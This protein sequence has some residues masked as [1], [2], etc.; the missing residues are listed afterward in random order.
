M[1]VAIFSVSDWERERFE[2]LKGKGW[3]IHLFEEKLSQD[4][5]PSPEVAD[6]AAIAVFADCK[7]GE[8][9]LSKFNRLG[10]VL[11]R[12]T[13]YDHIDLE[14]CRSRGIRVYFVPDYGSITVAEYTIGLMLAL[15][16][17]FRPMMEQSWHGSFRRANLRGLDLASKTV[18]LVGTGRIGREVAKRLA[19]FSTQILAFDKYPSGELQSSL[20]NLRYTQLEDLYRQSQIISFHVPLTEETKHIF[21]RDSLKL[22]KPSTFL[23]NTSRGPVVETEAIIEGLRNG[24]L[25][26][27]AL[28][29]FE[30][31]Q[32]LIEQEPFLSEDISQAELR[33]ALSTYH[34]LHS[35]RVILSP[36]NAYNTEEALQRIVEA[37]IAN[38]E[39]FESNRETPTR[40][41]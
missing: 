7:V 16:R 12:S 35:D 11:T 37:T 29:T 9:V 25:A 21:N 31:E 17:R 23:V 36:H 14:A 20:P 19:A 18:G 41:L 4:F 10:A 22:L 30:S 28:D 32:F 40:L 39:A 15:L 2:S 3:E 34:L 13:G 26:G 1:K 6:V 38:L 33:K 5:E 8:E 27:V 24:K